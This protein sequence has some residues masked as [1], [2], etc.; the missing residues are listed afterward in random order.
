MKSGAFEQVVEVQQASSALQDTMLGYV[1][2][3]VTALASSTAIPDV[4]VSHAS[5]PE[6]PTLVSSKSAPTLPDFSK[7]SDPTEPTAPTLETTEVADVDIPVFSA[8]APNITFPSFDD[9]PFPDDP[10]NAPALSDI[11]IPDDPEFTLPDPPSWDDIDVPTMPDYVTPNFEGT[12]PVLPEMTTPGQV[13]AFEQADFSPP[14]WDALQ[15]QLLEDLQNGGDLTNL[16]A[17]AGMFAEQ[18]RW[19]REDGTQRKE[20]IEAQWRAKGYSRLPGPAQAQLRLVDLDTEKSLAATRTQATA[21]QAELA[22][23]YKQFVIEQA[24]TVTANI[25]LAHWNYA[26]QRVFDAARVTAEMAYQ[27]LDARVKVHNLA[28][29]LYQ[30]DAAVFE[31]KIKAALSALEAYKTAMEGAKILGDL[32]DIDVKVYLGKLQGVGQVIEVYKSRMQAAQI[33]AQVN[34][35]RLQAF[36]SEVTAYTARV[37]AVRAHFDALVAQ[38]SGEKAKADVFTAQVGAYTAQI[39]GSKTLAEIGSIQSGIVSDRNKVKAQLYDSA[40]RAYSAKW[41]GV[42]TEVDRLSKR[43]DAIVKLYQAESAADA[44]ENDSKARLYAAAVQGFAV[45]A[46]VSIKEA[47][48]IL[49][50]AQ[51]IAEINQKALAVVAQVSGQGLASSLSQVHV[52]AGLS[53]SDSTSTSD[54][55]TKATSTSTST[56]TSASKSQSFSENYNYSQSMSV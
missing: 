39:G 43:A 21:K 14:L 17:L 51:T 30:A 3:A 50:R 34:T 12:R 37:N 42:A 22:V 15:A 24:G 35:S 1:T 48:L 20:Q 2:S 6:A 27:E 52:T 36:E 40:V 46:D 31:S 45:E 26:N 25:S 38:I 19:I 56:S 4:E 9:I 32:R 10:G 28:L 47:Q 8:T 33:Q 16:F 29:A 23:Q 11:T 5:T 54:S 13:F 44:G 7:S 49:G 18:E 41:Q 55:T 53:S